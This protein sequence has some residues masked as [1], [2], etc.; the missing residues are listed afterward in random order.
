MK[1]LSLAYDGFY[2][3]LSETHF[4]NALKKIYDGFC[5]MMDFP[6]SLCLSE[7]LPRFLEIFP[8]HG[9]IFL[10]YCIRL[11][12]EFTLYQTKN[13]FR[14]HMPLGASLERSDHS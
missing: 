11:N 7:M 4:E 14:V 2:E 6:Y 9:L 5:V 13:G 3:H 8:W 1:F 12:T 10:V